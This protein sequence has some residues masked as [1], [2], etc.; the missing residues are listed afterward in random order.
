MI[1]LLTIKKNIINE[2]CLF[3]MYKKK[4]IDFSD[5]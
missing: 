2:S 5:Y 1:L 3:F 4:K